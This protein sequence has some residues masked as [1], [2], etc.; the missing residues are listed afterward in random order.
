MCN[1]LHVWRV[2]Q[3][4]QIGLIILQIFVNE[5]KYILFLTIFCRFDYDLVLNRGVLQAGAL[6]EKQP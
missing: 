5:K 2:I 1:R 6:N 4:T 3:Y